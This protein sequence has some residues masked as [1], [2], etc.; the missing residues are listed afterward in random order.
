MER[1]WNKEC[2]LC[3]CAQRTIDIYRE[4]TCKNKGINEKKFENGAYSR[5]H[6][7]IH[8]SKLFGTTLKSRFPRSQSEIP[9]LSKVG[10]HKTQGPS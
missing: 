8:E 7:L 6:R 9:E 4:T 10:I 2:G 5:S 3:V 1:R